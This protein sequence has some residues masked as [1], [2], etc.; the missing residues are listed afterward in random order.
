MFLPLSYK[1]HQQMLDSHFAHS[2]SIVKGLHL[3]LSSRP[4]AYSGPSGGISWL[5]LFLLSVALTDQ[6]VLH[7]HGSTAA[8]SKTI[9]LQ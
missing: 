1:A 4:V 7:T 9:A 6:P 5:E 3:L 2:T 8:S